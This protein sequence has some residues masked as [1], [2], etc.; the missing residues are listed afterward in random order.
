L[1]T[2]SVDANDDKLD[3]VSWLPFADKCRC[4]LIMFGQCKTGT[5]WDNM[6]TQLQP[7]AF[8]KR[9]MSE[10]YIHNPLRAFCVVEAV[11]RARWHGHSVYSGILF[12]RCRIVDFC[13]KPN[14]ALLGKIRK[15]ATAAQA[16]ISF[17]AK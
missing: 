11:N 15:W 2:G 16:T 4:Q 14:S 3:T 13:E 8:I 12:D 5:N 7:T 9:W 6:L 1:D 17:K 10:P